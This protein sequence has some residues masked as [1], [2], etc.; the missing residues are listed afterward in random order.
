M[1]IHVMS[2]VWKTELGGPTRKAVAMKLADCA[3]DDGTS[4][5]PSVR[6]VSRETEMSERTVQETIRH[7]VEIGLL[8]PVERGGR[9]P[10]STNVYRFN[11]PTLLVMFKTTTE[12]WAKEDADKGAAGAPF[13]NSRVKLT[14]AKGAA[15]SRK[16]CS[17]RTQSIIE[18]SDNPS[19]RF[20][21][22]QT[23]KKKTPGT[24]SRFVSEDALDRVRA[25][26]PGWD[27]QALLKRF[28][29]WP[30]SANA[31]SMDAAFVGW[32][33]NFTKGKPPAGAVMP[34][35]LAARE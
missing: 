1:S 34:F 21:T 23:E 17:W 26:A 6:R 27:R 20:S 16:G 18:P 35:K 3:A 22:S 5:F 15:D 25:V 24:V 11:M 29:E 30:G 4:V 12:K 13:G 7:F 19:G 31:R 9:G 10:G 28:L 33:K 32:A 14:A 8:L 2:L